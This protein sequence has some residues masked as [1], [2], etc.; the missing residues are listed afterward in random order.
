MEYFLRDMSMN[1]EHLGPNRWY[2]GQRS[3]SHSFKGF[4][5]KILFDIFPRMNNVFGII[6]YA[7][8][9]KVFF[10]M[11]ETEQTLNHD[12]KPSF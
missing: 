9:R 5:M 12:K 11:A 1:Q 10:C 3:E 8:T 4:T 7:C 2:H 6:A